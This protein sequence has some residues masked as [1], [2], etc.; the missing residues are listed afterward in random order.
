VRDVL[1]LGL[2]QSPAQ[3]G[4]VQPVARLGPRHLDQVVQLQH[5]ALARLEGLAVR[6]V[7]G[8]E[9]DVLQRASSA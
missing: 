6:T 1:E 9:A 2:G 5:P 3:T 7:H 4:F 8:A